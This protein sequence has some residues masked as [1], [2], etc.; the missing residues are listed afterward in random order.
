MEFRRQHYV[1]E[2]VNRMHNGM[3]KIRQEE[4]PLLKVPDS[5]KKIIIVKELVLP[6]HNDNGTAIMSLQSFLM[7]EDSLKI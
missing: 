7:D 3:I 6:W 2:L 4:R 5:F 1:T